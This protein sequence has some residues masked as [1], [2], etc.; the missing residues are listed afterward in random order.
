MYAV[1]LKEALTLKQTHTFAVIMI[2]LANVVWLNAGERIRSVGHREKKCVAALHTCSI[3]MHRKG[4][5]SLVPLGYCHKLG[6]SPYIENPESLTDL[7]TR[8][9]TLSKC[10]ILKNNLLIL[11]III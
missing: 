3:R 2:G 11:F 4:A 1:A 5:E 10:H 7:H 8:V 6:A 9:R